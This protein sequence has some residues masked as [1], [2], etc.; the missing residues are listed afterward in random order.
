[1]DTYIWLCLLSTKR[2]LE[3]IDRW[4]PKYKLKNV[5]TVKIQR[6]K[7]L[8]EMNP[9]ELYDTTMNKETRTLKKVLY[10]DYIEN[11]LIFTKLMGKEV[12]S[13]KK[14]IIANA[15][16]RTYYGFKWYKP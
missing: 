14:F 3:Q 7:G 16:T 12:K 9:E 11:D 15:L 5:D 6:Y 1:M 4:A 2:I 13:R 10:E 8:G